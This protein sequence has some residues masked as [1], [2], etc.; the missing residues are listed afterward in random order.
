MARKNGNGNGDDGGKEKATENSNKLRK[1]GDADGLEE[2][3][4][5]TA[6]EPLDRM[7][8]YLKKSKMDEANLRD[9]ISLAEAV[10][11]EDED[12]E[13][14]IETMQRLF[15]LLDPD[16]FEGDLK[17]SVKLAK[18][19]EPVL[20]LTY[21]AI[22]SDS[23]DKTL[24]SLERGLDENPENNAIKELLAEAYI[25]ANRPNKGIWLIEEL[26]ESEPDNIAYSMKLADAYFDRKW[27]NKAA[28]QYERTIE[29][30]QGN[31]L[32]W[33][34]LVFSFGLQAK[35]KEAE[36][37]CLDGINTLKAFRKES[38]SLYSEAFIL[39]DILDKVT[40]VE[41]LESIVNL[42]SLEIPEYIDEADRV[43]DRLLQYMEMENRFDA[44][45]FLTE[46][47]G[48]VED[49]DG[50][51]ILRL[52]KA[53]LL[54]KR[55]QLDDCPVHLAHML[56]RKIFVEFN[57]FLIDNLFD[58]DDFDY[59][60]DE[61]DFDFDIVGDDVRE[62]DISDLFSEDDDDD[63]DDD[64]WPDYDYF[65]YETLENEEFRVALITSTIEH[66]K[67]LIALECEILADLSSYRQYI[68]RIKV[69]EPELYFLNTDFFDMAL[70]CTKA[71]AKKIIEARQ[72]QL[73]M[74][75]F[76][77]DFEGTYPSNR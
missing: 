38:L 61:D 26:C 52:W 67:Y 7:R 6:M 57:T 4:D 29:L 17:E 47:V 51:I 28:K 34:R 32:A 55:L 63:D 76:V 15:S 18:A 40:A 39:Q 42:M 10:A 68:M 2:R 12:F 75:G 33:E 66:N 13:L 1:L 45:P 62:F 70:S 31:V 65:D 74:A 11:L 43:L 48:L 41:Y 21:S 59:D 46:I 58:D 19:I 25:I 9:F 73:A 24:K 20:E 49:I 54:Q 14:D 35:E 44:L 53:E 64:D 22:G 30:D 8:E 60:D 23:I 37:A 3:S 71:I 56:D 69:E 36:R 27:F 5:L 77:P 50:L 16:D 72:E